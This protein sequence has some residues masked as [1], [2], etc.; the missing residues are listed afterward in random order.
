MIRNQNTRESFFLLASVQFIEENSVRRPQHRFYCHRE[1]MAR[2]NAAAGSSAP[3]SISPGIFSDYAT[4]LQ[5]AALATTRLAATTL[6]QDIAFHRSIHVSFAEDIDALST[7]VL[8]LTNKLVR[9]AG[10]VDSGTVGRGTLE[11]QEDVLDGFKSLIVD[12]IDGLFERTDMCLDDYLGR[13]KEPATTVLALP[14]QG[15]NSSK[16]HPITF[17]VH[18]R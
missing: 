7:R 13:K 16:V 12:P 15:N 11:D 4:S 14:N 5:S 10:S 2:T 6:P 17:E 18:T 3:S 1:H 8:R 9:L